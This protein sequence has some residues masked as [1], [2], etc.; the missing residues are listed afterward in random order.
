MK[1][2][3]LTPQKH[4]GPPLAPEVGIFRFLNFFL[5][6]FLEFSETF[7]MSSKQ[8]R[9][10]VEGNSADMCAGKFPLTSMGG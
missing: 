8:S 7:E 2:G 1:K 4:W 5:L 3:I 6:N 9:E 10:M